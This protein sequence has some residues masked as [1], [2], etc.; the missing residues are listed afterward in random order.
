MKYLMAVLLALMGV[1]NA[2]PQDPQA[3]YLIILLD[4]SGSMNERMTGSRMTKIEAAKVALLTVLDKVS[5]NT[6]IGLVTFEGV[7]FKPGTTTIQQAK[8]FI[9]GIA[10][11]GSTP[12]GTFSKVAADE[13]LAVRIKNK[14]YG[15]YR[16][17]IV[18]DGEVDSS[19]RG[20]LQKNIPD[21]RS[22]GIVLDTIGVDMASDHSLSKQSRKYMNANNPNS[23]TEVVKQVVGEVT[24]QN[25]DNLNN[26]SYE[27]IKPLPENL[28]KAI[29]GTSYGNQPIGEI[30]KEVNLGQTV[31]D[32]VMQNNNTPTGTN[33]SV[34]WII[35][36]I[37]AS[38]LLLCVVMLAH[39]SRNY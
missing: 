16:L 9:Q 7:V 1:C 8:T 32:S 27:I 11:D 17:V 3:N 29:V 33:W 21:I 34:L 26:D 14:G 30:A 20:R 4:T 18:T 2:H 23:F 24:S 39:A 35:A 22:R 25:D 15:S 12:L 19:D 36:A 5:P 31:I 6:H 28:C 10:C 38:G 13:L 37:A